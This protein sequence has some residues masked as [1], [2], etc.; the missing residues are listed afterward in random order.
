MPQA[1]RQPGDAPEMEK[2]LHDPSPEEN[3]DKPD[4]EGVSSPE[5]RESTA[6]MTV[7]RSVES[8]NAWARLLNGQRVEIVKASRPDIIAGVNLKMKT[9][10]KSK[11]KDAVDVDIA[12]P[13][14]AEIMDEQ[15]R[16]SH[17]DAQEVSVLTAIFRKY[18]PDIWMLKKLDHPEPGQDAEHGLDP[19]Q[20]GNRT[21]FDN[22][23]IFV[24]AA[25]RA[26]EMKEL[27]AHPPAVSSG[28][29]ETTFD[30][31]P[32]W[33]YLGNEGFIVKYRH[34]DTN[35]VTE[36][37]FLYSRDSQVKNQEEFEQR[38]KG[39]ET[40]EREPLANLKKAA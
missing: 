39:F 6:T 16:E 31:E 17:V 14:A 11:A 28:T 19:K 2:E 13:K 12:D 18:G 7:M 9:V 37:R 1:T 30:V 10:E 8:G 15:L 23:M 25:S 33:N 21:E 26:D 3:S 29:L 40:A 5:Q 35:V 24:I 38:K 34:P 22:E 20:M 4:I 32:R 36:I 27:F